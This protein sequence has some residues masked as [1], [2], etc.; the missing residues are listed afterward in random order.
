MIKCTL[1]GCEDTTLIDSKIRNDVNDEFKMYSCGKCK[2]HFL[3]PRPQEEQLQNYYDGK[4]REEVHT[5]AYYEFEKLDKVVE[6]FTP[7]AIERAKRVS[8]EL[9]NEDDVLE[10]GCASGYFLIQLA[11]KVHRICGT[12]WDRK[13]QEYIKER[14]SDRGIEVDYNPQDF[15]SKFDKIFMFHVL[16]HIEAPV[17][18]LKGLKD[19]L[20]PGGCIYIEVP[21]VDD[22][23]VK[24]YDCQ[25]FKD[26]YYKKAH[27]YNF[28]EMG[29]K[30]VFE[31][32]GYQYS[33][34]FIHRYDLS[35]HLYWLGKG[36][37][38]GKGLYSDI[39]GEEANRAYVDALRK[40]KQTDT[41]FAKIWL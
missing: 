8:H 7:E 36:I 22:V 19:I 29:L 5:N 37:P 24:T 25:P 13:S 17:E 20:K 21:N 12:E 3:Y 30:Y 38:G 26:F 28:N 41:L 35:N 31:N 32:A 4:F 39:L 33:I 15:N 34:D 27:L 23:M 40:N 9:T 2:T 14:F 10:I 6:K 18:F 16:E 1:C 11:G